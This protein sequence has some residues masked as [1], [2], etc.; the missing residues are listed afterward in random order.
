MANIKDVSLS[1]ILINFLSQESELQ[2]SQIS[3]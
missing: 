1:E 2:I 3:P